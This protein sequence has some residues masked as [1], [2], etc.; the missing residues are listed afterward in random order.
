MSLRECALSASKGTR[1]GGVPTKAG[2]SDIFCKVLERVGNYGEKGDHC[3]ESTQ[4]IK[5]EGKSEEPADEIVQAKKRGKEKGRR[6]GARVYASAGNFVG[7]NEA[8]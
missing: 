3:R 6:S 4:G 5:E 1:G 8:G 2:R 7:V